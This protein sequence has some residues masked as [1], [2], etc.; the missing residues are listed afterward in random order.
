M[1]SVLGAGAA[2]AAGGAVAGSVSI[3]QVCMGAYSV[4]LSGT[5]AAGAGAAL[6]AAAGP[7]AAVLVVAL[8]IANSA[9][10]VQQANLSNNAMT[11]NSVYQANSSAF[12]NYAQVYQ[13]ST[14][15]FEAHEA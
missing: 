6:G 15:S 7:L 3:T 4:S 11:A 5:G 14:V 2:I 10:N 12:A 8:F 9:S 1:G 13:A